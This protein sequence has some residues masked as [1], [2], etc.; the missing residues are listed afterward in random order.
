VTT[1]TTPTA[2]ERALTLDILRGRYAAGSRL[3][4]VRELAQQHGVN[5]ATI[6]RVVSRLETRGLVEARQ[7]SGLRV[8][9]PETSADLSLV[10]YWLV[11]KLGEPR[12]AAAILGDFLGLRRAVAVQLLV[13]HRAAI[14]ARLPALA[15]LAA[16]L[17]AT[18]RDDVRALAEADLAF[19]RALLRAT[20]NRVAV[21]LLNT[22]GRVLDELP[23][24]AQAMYADPASN[25]AS[26]GEVLAA[27]AAGGDGAA[28]AIDAT[29]ARIDAATVRRFRTGLI[30]A[31]KGS[32]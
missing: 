32:A 25:A 9:D 29:I 28:A 20:G 10:P 24:V 18:P 6:Q 8:N 11:A 2:I 13:Q 15:S 26:M 7:G 23:E 12:E 1:E 17:A 19:A 16:A 22:T 5:P 4:S 21:A 3:P 31:R 30:A 27:L 14:L